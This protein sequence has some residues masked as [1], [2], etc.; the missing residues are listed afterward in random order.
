MRAVRRFVYLGNIEYIENNRGRLDFR[1]QEAQFQIEMQNS[2]RVDVDYMRDYE[3]IPAAFEISNTVTV[4]VGGY[5]YNNLLTS[6]AFGPQHLLSGSV[7]FQSGQLYGG[8]KHTLGL[9]GGRLEVTKQLALEP[10]IS[11]NRVVLPWGRFTTSVIT[12]RT[13]F[14]MN[15]R[16]FVSALVQYASASHAMSVN[17]RFRWEYQPGSEMFVVY[18]DGRDTALGGF[19]TLMNRAFIV[20]ITK[21]FR[22]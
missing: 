8:T 21:L 4:P 2:D 17:A 11:A 12:N 5:T 1:E 7:S 15:P 18:S 3:R 10:G 6:Y 14:T 16:A 9:G 20:K 13:T 22:L 19:P